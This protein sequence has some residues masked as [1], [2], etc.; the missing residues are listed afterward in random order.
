MTERDRVEMRQLARDDRP[1]RDEIDPDPTDDERIIRKY[2]RTA[3]PASQAP[4]DYGLT[5]PF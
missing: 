4:P 1:T 5:D 3:I 2:G